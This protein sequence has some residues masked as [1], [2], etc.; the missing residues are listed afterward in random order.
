MPTYQAFN[1]RINSGVKYESRSKGF[2][3]LDVK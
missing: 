2:K 3:V 1:S